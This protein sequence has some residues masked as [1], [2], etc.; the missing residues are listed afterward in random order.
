MR[1][2]KLAGYRHNPNQPRRA[3]I[4]GEQALTPEERRWMHRAARVLADCPP[5]LV[6]YTTGDMTL[7]VARAGVMHD[8]EVDIG[9]AERRANASIGW[10]PCATNIESRAG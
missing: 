2:K 3:S 5:G 4:V 8:E 10:I 7:G 9:V 1:E 6:L